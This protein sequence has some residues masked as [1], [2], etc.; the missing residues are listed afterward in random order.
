MMLMYLLADLTIDFVSEFCPQYPVSDD[1]V[2][3]L[4]V[5]RRPGLKPRVIRVCGVLL[6]LQLPLDVVADLVLALKQMKFIQT[7]FL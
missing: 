5:G 3:L 4:Q 7:V 1:E 6:L 2:Q